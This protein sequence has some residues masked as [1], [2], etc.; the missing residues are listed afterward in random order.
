MTTPHFVRRLAAVSLLALSLATF[1]PLGLNL[2]SAAGNDGSNK[3]TG[4]PAKPDAAGD[5]GKGN[6]GGNTGNN[7]AGHDSANGN[8][9]GVN[10]NSNAPV[11]N[12]SQS[13]T[14][15]TGNTG[16]NNASHGNSENAPGCA[17][18]AGGRANGV[19]PPN[20]GVESQTQTA[21]GC[22]KTDGDVT[23]PTGDQP[24]VVTSPPDAPTPATADQPAVVVT[25]PPDA[26][27]ATPD[28]PVVLTSP[29]DVTPT[30]DQPVVSTP[31]QPITVVVT[32]PITTPSGGT[33]QPGTTVT[34]LVGSVPFSGE[35]AGATISAP[36]VPAFSAPTF[37]AD[38]SSVILESQ[39]AGIS[40]PGSLPSTGGGYGDR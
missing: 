3:N 21:P 27:P 34:I 5:Q 20:G 32:S 18:G 8:S 30:A 35:V 29:P 1:A 13:K 16:A 19:H 9:G 15:D 11:P 38:T 14:C 37:T 2:A 10:A 28:Q 31:T 7:D 12:C 24:H 26:T 33:I 23:P 17:F 40:V 4:Q 6:A 39:V 36:N 25:S 22:D